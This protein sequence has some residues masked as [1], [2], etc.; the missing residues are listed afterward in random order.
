MQNKDK[1]KLKMQLEQEAEKLIKIDGNE[2][3]ISLISTCN[4]LLKISE[5]SLEEKNVP[6]EVY[7][8]YLSFANRIKSF[9]DLHSKNSDVSEN[10]ANELQDLL[11][12]VRARQSEQDIISKRLSMAKKAN[13]ELK[14]QIETNKNSLNEQITI[15]E[16]L[17]KM[18]AD[19]TPE[20]IEEQ[21]KKNDNTLATLNQQKKL[22]NDLKD[23]QREM[24]SE[25][26]QIAEEVKEIEYSIDGIPKEIVALR[27]K[28]KELAS[29]LKELQNAEIEYSVEKQRELK[30]NIDELTPI[31]E[32]N[33]VAT[34][35]LQNR[36]ESLEKQNTKYDSERHTLTTDLIDIINETLGQLKNIMNEHTAFL[37]ETEMTAKTL[38]E[39]LDK[40]QKKRDEYRHWYDAVETPL[41]AMMAELGYPESAELRKTLNIN[42]VQTIRTHMEEIRKSL[43]KLDHILSGCATAAQKDLQIVK[44]RAGQ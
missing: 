37:N 29:L 15:G 41:E 12:A 16:S 34:E 7:A 21:K 31:V 42:Q 5:N 18:L 14:I 30:K 10:T 13:A 25:K 19:C 39:N 27:A 44:R 20:M 4:A 26:Q 23:K 38:A 1:Q 36:K 35:I 43:M 3:V 33:K 22:L 24:D 2:L 8:V 11:G 40:C 28:Y 17:Q 9:Y 6:D 32:E